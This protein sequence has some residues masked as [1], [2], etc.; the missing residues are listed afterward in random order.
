MR[1][2]SGAGPSDA[3]APP[4]GGGG[5]GVSVRTRCARRWRTGGA[6]GFGGGGG[7]GGAA[8]RRGSSCRSNAPGRE[9]HR[10]A[11]RPAR[12]TLRELQDTTGAKIVIRGRGSQGGGDDGGE[13][14]HVLIEGADDA[15]REASQ[16]V[17]DILFNPEH[18]QS[19]KQ[20]QLAAARG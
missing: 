20:Q 18:A 13:N 4:A 5:A 11:A 3:P 2:L 1:C 19:L 6:G 15:V 14:L 10:A 9:L 12:A 8:R 17:D 7:G 16:K